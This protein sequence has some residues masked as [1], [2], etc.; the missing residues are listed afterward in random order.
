[1]Q[2]QLKR[3]SGSKFWELWAWSEYVSRLQKREWKEAGARRSTLMAPYLASA[4]IGGGGG[5]PSGQAWPLG[6]PRWTRLP[7]SGPRRTLAACDYR[8]M[9]ELRRN[10]FWLRDNY[11]VM[12]SLC[13]HSRARAHYSPLI[14]IQP[15][16]TLSLHTTHRASNG[17]LRPCPHL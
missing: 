5:R 15:K 14:P 7:P 6:A 12:V 8:L 1:M 2:T 3:V 10:W 16:Q 17:H 4:L 11:L 13:S 9:H